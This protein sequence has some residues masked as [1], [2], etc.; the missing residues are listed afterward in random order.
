LASVLGSGMAFLDGTAV[1][2]A[3]PAL[4]REL[5]A[6]LSGLQWAVDAY[7]LTLS[8]LVLTGGALGDAYGQRRVFLAGIL[9]FTAASVLCGL[10]PSAL[11]F[12]L[13]RAVQGM[14]AALLVP[15]SL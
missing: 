2:V 13:V 14:G 5:G 12:A 9:A 8:A 15:A 3:L 7:L 1:N 10:A 11:S 6:G 4:G